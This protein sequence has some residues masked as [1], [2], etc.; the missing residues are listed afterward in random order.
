MHDPV[1]QYS[2]EEAIAVG[3]GLEELDY[4][5]IEEPSQEFDL[6]GLKRLTAAID[7]PVMALES[8]PENPYLA[9]PYL[10][11]DAIDIVRQTGLGIT[12]QMKLANLAETLGK[13]CHGSNPHVVAAIRN[14]DWW[15]VSA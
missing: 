10:T 7:L 12:G 3:R 6:N 5:W 2:V 1:Q 13:N 8:I 4:L 9:T 14:D 15:E 11:A